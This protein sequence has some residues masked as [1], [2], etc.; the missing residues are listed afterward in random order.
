MSGQGGGAEQSDKNSYY[1]LWLVALIGFIAG[2]I[3][4]A[5]SYQ[6]KIAFIAIRLWELASIHFFLG[7]F[8]PDF[9]WIGESI[10]GLIPAVSSDLELVQGLRP[11]GLTLDIADTLS[12]TA[13]RYLRY[14]LAIF[15]VALSIVVFKT[16]IQM[17]LKKKFDMNSLARQEQVNWPQIKI[18]TK[19]DILNEDLDSGPWA[20]AMT[21]MQFAKKNRLVAIEFADVSATQFSKVQAA[22]FKV[23]L[24]KARAERAF[25]AQL[26]RGWHGAEN[27]PPHRRALFAVFVARGN[28]DTK[29]AQALVSQLAI[30]AA[31]GQLDCS[32]VDALWKKHIKSKKIQEICA[33]HAYEFT[34]FIS[35]LLYAREDGVV[36]SSDFL[37]V[38]P[39]DRRLW[40]VINNVGR[41]T[42][43]VEVGGIFSHW[44]YEMALKRAL[45][46]PRIDPAVEALNIALSE[47]IYVPDEKEREAL[48]KQRDENEKAAKEAAAKAK[49]QAEAEELSVEQSTV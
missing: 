42:P 6:L 32:G 20:M 48:V 25:S 10:Q 36:A 31:D 11:D 37:W 33:S 47:V 1:I 43:A 5:F 44:Y 49:E 19:F 18:A 15:L 34:L 24:D 8:S 12:L 38:K 9:P 41:Q 4:W 45:N 2:L 23:T 27:M 26:G 29:A 16:N 28:R 7:L 35:V 40:Y 22:E 3:W 14:P 30:S 39:I 21:P 13:G 46:S 17:R